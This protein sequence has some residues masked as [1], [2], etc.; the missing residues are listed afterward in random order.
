MKKCCPR[1]SVILFC[2]KQ[3]QVGCYPTKICSFAGDGEEDE[4]GGETEPMASS[5]QQEQ[6]DGESRGERSHL[7]VWQ[8]TMQ[9]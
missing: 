6:Q 2:C 4:V 8:V 7:I 9:D 3:V 5:Q 1:S